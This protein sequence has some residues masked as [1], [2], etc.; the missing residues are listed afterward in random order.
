M[1]SYSRALER[2]VPSPQSRHIPAPAR[3]APVRRHHVWQTPD[4]RIA[5]N[6]SQPAAP[7]RLPHW[8]ATPLKRLL[9]AGLYARCRNLA[10]GTP[11][12]Q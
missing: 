7:P 8:L 12:R 1:A 2:I 10:M 4:A 9:G 11:A 6:P 5:P 3:P